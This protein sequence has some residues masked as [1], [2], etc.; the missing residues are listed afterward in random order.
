M[1]LPPRAVKIDARSCLASVRRR[2]LQAAGSGIPTLGHP[3]FVTACTLQMVALSSLCI[4][5]DCDQQ[6]LDP[7]RPWDKVDQALWDQMLLPGRAVPA[8]GE[9]ARA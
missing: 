5:C 4:Y 2:W 1:P 9:A 3:P 6:L 7:K 8:L